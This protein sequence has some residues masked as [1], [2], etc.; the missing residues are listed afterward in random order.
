MKYTQ[1]EVRKKIESFDA[2]MYYYDENDHGQTVGFQ[3]TTKEFMPPFGWDILR[4]EIVGKQTIRVL[5]IN[6]YK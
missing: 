6:I 2:I 3:L 5:M 1:E 4:I